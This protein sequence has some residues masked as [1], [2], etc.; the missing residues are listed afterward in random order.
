MGLQAEAL[1]LQR[2]RPAAAERVEHRGRVAVAGGHDLRPGRLQNLAVG[3]VLPLHQVFDDAEQPFS[4]LLLGLFGREPV[5]M[6]GGVVDQRGEQH[7]P[8]GGERTAGP[9]QVQRGWM[10]VADRLLPGG[11]PI[12]G[13]QRQGDL[14]QLLLVGHAGT[15]ERPASCFQSKVTLIVPNGRSPLPS[16]GCRR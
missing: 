1:G 12:D 16:N 11:L 15:S 14:D 4:L 8:A 13:L 5:G 3:A 9:P 6:G 7:R 10:A 2:D